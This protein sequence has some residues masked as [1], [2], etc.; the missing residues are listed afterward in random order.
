MGRNRYGNKKCLRRFTSQE[1]RETFLRA[2][3]A[4]GHLLA[5][6]VHEQAEADGYVKVEAEDVGLEGGAEAEGGLGVGEPSHQTAAGLLRWRA[7]LEADQTVEHVGAGGKLE[8][9]DGAFG[10]GRW[11]ARR[12]VRRRVRRGVRRRPRRPRRRPRPRHRAQATDVGESEEEEA[13][14]EEEGDRGRELGGGHG[15]T[16]PSVPGEWLGCGV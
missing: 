8:G 3:E 11:R 13:E 6:V 15:L 14:R 7:D 16:V 1:D 10:T 2:L 4:G 5:T 9:V 12:G